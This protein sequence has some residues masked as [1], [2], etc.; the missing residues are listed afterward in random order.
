MKTFSIEVYLEILKFLPPRHILI[1]AQTCKQICL[2]SRIDEL[3]RAHIDP[4]WIKDGVLASSSNIAEKKSIRCMGRELALV[5]LS[6]LS[7]TKDF[8]YEHEFIE[9]AK[10]HLAAGRHRACDLCL[11][12]AGA[13]RSRCGK[14]TPSIEA[15]IMA[16]R[17]LAAATS[18]AGPPSGQ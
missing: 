10:Q 17:V 8:H 11:C 18:S 16:A 12:H 9:A 13:A 2:A 5:S 7:E 4:E 14:P 15:S 3:W 6:V 1:A